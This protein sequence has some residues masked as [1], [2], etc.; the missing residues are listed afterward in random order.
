LHNFIAISKEKVTTYSARAAK[1]P[2]ASI[3]SSRVDA[4][5]VASGALVVRTRVVRAENSSGTT[6]VELV[7]AGCG[8][9]VVLGSGTAGVLW[10]YMLV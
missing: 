5:G 6:A 3:E 2:A 4:V 1:A 10:R 7:A 9:F 8:G